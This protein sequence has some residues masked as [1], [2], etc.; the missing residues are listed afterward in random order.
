VAAEEFGIRNGMNSVTSGDGD[1]LDGNES[2]ITLMK[3][4]NVLKIQES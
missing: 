4:R 3:R 2:Q 1:P